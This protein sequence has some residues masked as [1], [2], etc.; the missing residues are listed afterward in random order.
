[1]DASEVG[2]LAHYHLISGA[3]RGA[4][5]V[6]FEYRGATLVLFEYRGG[7]RTY[8]RVIERI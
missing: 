4:V 6:L 7:H 8:K 3:I 2:S 1:M 5:F